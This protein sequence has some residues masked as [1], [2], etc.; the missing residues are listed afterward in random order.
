MGGDVLRIYEELK[1]GSDDAEVR[2]IICANS[3]EA[4]A[5]TRLPENVHTNR[6]RDQV[7]NVKGQYA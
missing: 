1:G 6:Y 5:H 3:P 2:G 4:T 7:R